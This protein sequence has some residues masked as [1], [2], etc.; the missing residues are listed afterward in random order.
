VLS[1]IGSAKSQETMQEPMQ[2]IRI[3]RGARFAALYCHAHYQA[4]Y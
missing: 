2:G 3:G 1:T 4:H